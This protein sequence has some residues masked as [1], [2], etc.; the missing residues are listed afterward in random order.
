MQVSMYVAGCLIAVD[1]EGRFCVNDLHRASG[2]AQR[3]QPRYWLKL[4]Q[5]QELVAVL[6]D[7]AIS[8]SVVRGGPNQGTYVPRE[9]VYA[10]AMWISPTF[11]LQVIRAY[12]AQRSPAPDSMAALSDPAALRSLLLDYSDR[13]LSLTTTVE[14]Q[15]PKVAALERI[16]GTNGSFS[17]TEAAKNLQ[18]A[19][20]ELSAWLATNRWIY[21]HPLGRRHWLG[22]QPR[23]TGGHLEHKVVTGQRIDGTEWS[24]TQVRVT[25]KG[26]ARLAELLEKPLHSLAA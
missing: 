18:I 4:Q 5:T 17:V 22:Y 12:D 9:L 21:R 20:R 14:D 13:M 8:L 26:M 15:R 10:Y 7:S 25:A 6:A 24:N 2:G 11:H 3:H 23:I 19:P 1:D 16:A